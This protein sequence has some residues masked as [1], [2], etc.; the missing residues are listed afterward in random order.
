MFCGLRRAAPAAKPKDRWRQDVT[1]IQFHR[2]LLCPIFIAYI[3]SVF[4]A[5]Y[6]VIWGNTLGAFDLSVRGFTVGSAT[7]LIAAVIFAARHV[8]LVPG[9]FGPIKRSALFISGALFVSGFIASGS[10][11]ALNQFLPS[12][13]AELLLTVSASHKIRG[14]WHVTFMDI[15]GRTFE[16]NFEPVPVGTKYLFQ[17]RVGVFGY[18]N[19]RSYERLP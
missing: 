13:K 2:Y 17:V 11:L 9:V 19:F 10:A 1:R 18:P 14:G 12:E 4:L 15:R 8:D 16:H 6:V 5:Y 3:V 7:G